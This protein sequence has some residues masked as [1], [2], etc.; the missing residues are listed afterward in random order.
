MGRRQKIAA[1]FERI[2]FAAERMVEVGHNTPQV[3]YMYVC[4]CGARYGASACVIGDVGGCGG[5]DLRCSLEGRE[6][7]V[8][9]LPYQNVR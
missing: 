1:C 5:A 2:V 6:M 3:G 4:V 9:D 8:D 7:H